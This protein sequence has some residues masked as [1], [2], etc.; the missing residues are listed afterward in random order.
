[1]TRAAR[2]ATR[3]RRPLGATRIIFAAVF[4]V[5]ALVAGGWTAHTYLAQQE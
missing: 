5:V 2:T 4:S 3:R 1:M